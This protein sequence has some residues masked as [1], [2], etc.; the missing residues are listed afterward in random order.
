V[1][2]DS[3][4]KE[5]WTHCWQLSPVDPGKQIQE[6]FVT[7]HIA[8]SE[9][10]AEQEQPTYWMEG[11]MHGVDMEEE[12]CVAQGQRFPPPFQLWKFGR[13]CHTRFIVNLLVAH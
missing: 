9:F 7:S 10:T 13:D 12:L 2:P 4:W 8:E 3:V 5:F 1:H 6:P 11:K